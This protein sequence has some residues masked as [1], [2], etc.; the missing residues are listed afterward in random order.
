MTQLAPYIYNQ[1]LR[2]ARTTVNQRMASMEEDLF[3][4]EQ[5]LPKTSR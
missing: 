1:A 2:D 3:A 4:L 5:K